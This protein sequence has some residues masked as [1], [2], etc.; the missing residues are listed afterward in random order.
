MK[1]K[2]HEQHETW[3]N[4]ENINFCENLKLKLNKLKINL[5]RIK[6][7][8]NQIYKCYRIQDKHTI[9]IC[10]FVLLLEINV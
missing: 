3:H 5:M 4:T 7:K 8:T 9:K 2:Q 6:T 1:D 10:S